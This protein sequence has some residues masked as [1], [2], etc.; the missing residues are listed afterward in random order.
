MD[1]V[2]LLLASCERSVSNSIE[3]VVRDVCYEQ[4]VVSC[5][6]VM[7]DREFARQ[8]SWKGFDLMIVT[9]NA[10]L[11][12]EGQTGSRADIDAVSHSI[13]DIKEKHKTPIIAV[14]VPMEYDAAL[15]EAGADFALAGPLNAEELRPAVAQALGIDIHVANND[16]AH[17]PFASIGEA[18]I[19]GFQRLTEA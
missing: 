9:V 6:R 1:T 3:V 17:S 8:G 2:K 18:L 11:P 15:L 14:G 13:R 10:L 7:S 19:R 5:A 12:S 4:A 16:Q